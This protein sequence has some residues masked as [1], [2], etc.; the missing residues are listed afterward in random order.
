VEAALKLGVISLFPELFKTLGVGVCQK[1]IEQGLVDLTL[2]NPRDYSHDK[3]GY[4]D[5]K[6]YGGGPGMVIKYQPL[7]DSIKAA[8]AALGENSKVIYFSPKGEKITQK[9]L[10]VI[11]STGEPL[12][13]I[14]GRYEG[15]DERVCQQFVDEQWSAGDLILSGG[16]LPALMMI[17]ALTR[18]VPGTL[19][20]AQ[21]AQE[22]SFSDG[23]LE[24]PHYT[25]PEEIDG[26]TV[27][28][29]LLNGNHKEIERWRL[30]QKLGTTWARRPDLLNAKP[31][32]AIE[33]ALLDEYIS[34]FKRSK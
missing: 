29:V 10:E 11:A 19:G 32:T 15:I 31:L 34:E 24:C 22:D 21:S 18:L 23:L 6:P 33:Q 12:L 9:K 2:W 28:Q 8:K 27:P 14:A 26:L 5:D 16:E 17:D 7:R 20:N 13:M 3:H 30:K 25:R 1:A 4:V